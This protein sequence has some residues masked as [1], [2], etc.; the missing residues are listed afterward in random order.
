MKQCPHIDR[1]RSEVTPFLAEA[2]RS[3]QMGESPWPLFINGPPGSGKTCAALCYLDHKGVGIYHTVETWVELCKEAAAG[4]ATHSTGYKRT[5]LDVRR[6]MRESL[7]VVIDEL[8]LRKLP[9]REYTNLHWAIDVRGSKKP[10]ICIS[11]LDLKRLVQVYDDRIASRLRGGTCV[12]TSGDRR[13][14]KG[15]LWP[16]KS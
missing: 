11:N 4:R 6:D 7:V 14:A 10:L 5:I 13:M 12:Q 2:I 15:I 9:D 16:R 1:E 8:G 3:C